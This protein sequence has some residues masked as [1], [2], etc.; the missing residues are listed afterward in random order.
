MSAQTTFR[1]QLHGFDFDNDWDVDD[2]YRNFVRSEIANAL[3]I[4]ITAITANPILGPALFSILG[5]AVGVVTALAPWLFATPFLIDGLVKLLLSKIGDA[6]PDNY[7][8][9]GGMAF[10]PLDYFYNRLVI[11]KGVS[12]SA[13][14]QFNVPPL[15]DPGALKLRNYIFSRFSDSWASGGVLHTMLQWFVILNTIPSDLGGGGPAVQSLC[16]PEWVKLAG[17]LD[18]G[19]PQPIAL[20]F[21]TWNIFDNHQLIAY[22]YGGDPFSGPAY[23]NVY[24]NRVPDQE[25]FIR[26]DFTKSQMSGTITDANGTVIEPNTSNG[27]SVPDPALRGFFCAN[28]VPMAP[29]P[30]WGVTEGLAVLPTSCQGV[31][32]GFALAATTANAFSFFQQPD[33]IT[34]IT[35]VVGDAWGIQTYPANYPS[36]PTADVWGTGPAPLAAEVSFMYPGVYVEFAKGFLQVVD[37]KGATVMDQFGE[38]LTG[39]VNLPSLAPPAVG[40][41]SLDVHAAL[42]ITPVNH[43]G[44]TCFFPYFE[45]GAVVLQVAPPPFASGDVTF[46]WHVKGVK[47]PNTT[48]QT[49]EIS[50]LPAAG[51]T[52]EVTVEVRDITT[53]CIAT[54]SLTFTVYTANQSGSETALC[55]LVHRLSDLI[56]PGLINP[57]GP[58]NPE[59]NRNVLENIAQIREATRAITTLADELE[60]RESGQ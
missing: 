14:K 40:S 24:D 26:F 44:D 16:K 42:V 31:N 7:G 50:K 4:A 48:S 17:L 23:I 41:V 22:G 28:Y 45:G 11:P 20:I 35:P 39:F 8:A 46:K 13:D 56:V 38:P 1:P 32:M 47:V 15:S 60:S 54:G 51:R 21:D 2:N 49:V 52:V 43:T 29:P 12:L 3:P 10:A 30:A 36:L 27:K 37:S 25:L 53:G 5:V 59:L 57:L 33:Q 6:L 55:H 18:L 19:K 9:C 58:D 34:K